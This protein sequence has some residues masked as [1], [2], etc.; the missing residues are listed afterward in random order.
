MTIQSLAPDDVRK[1]RAARKKHAEKMPMTDVPPPGSKSAAP[2]SEGKKAKGPKFGIKEDD[3]MF[4]VTSI[5]GRNAAEDVAGPFDT[6]DEA[7][8]ELERLADA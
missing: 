4:I 3:G 5:E 1:V 2:E 6:E 7:K 8:A